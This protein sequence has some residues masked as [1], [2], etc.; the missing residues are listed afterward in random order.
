MQP[1]TTTQAPAEVIR[2][3][4]DALDTAYRLLASIK[5]D[6][7]WDMDDECRTD[8]ERAEKWLRHPPC[9]L[10]RLAQNVGDQT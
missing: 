4:V 1:G 5:Q 2:L 9:D 7:R 10:A 8:L 6:D 3:A